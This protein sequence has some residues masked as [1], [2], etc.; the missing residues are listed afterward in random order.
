MSYRSNFSYN[1]S[2]NSADLDRL[3]IGKFT[4]TGKGLYLGTNLLI[5]LGVI[6]LERSSLASLILYPP[7]FPTYLRRDYSPESDRAIH[8]LL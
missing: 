6:F 7:S 2:Q 3:S 1:T 4:L 8:R 5:E